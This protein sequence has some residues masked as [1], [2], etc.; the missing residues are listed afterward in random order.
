[1][2]VGGDEGV[3]HGRQGIMETTKTE[4]VLIGG[5]VGAEIP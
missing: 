3:S 5:R 1:M 2:G 4:G